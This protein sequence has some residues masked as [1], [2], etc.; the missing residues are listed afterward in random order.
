MGG[1]AD[2]LA[3]AVG[4]AVLQADEPTLARVE[5]RFSAAFRLEFVLKGRT[6]RCA[7]KVIFH[8]EPAS[9]GGKVS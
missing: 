9:A 5:R 8:P 3:N 4:R 6:F 7:V 2:A 1:R